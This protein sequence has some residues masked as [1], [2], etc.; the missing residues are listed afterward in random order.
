ML[1]IGIIFGGCAPPAPVT[2]P[3]TPVALNSTPGP[4]FAWI[5][6]ETTW[7]RDVN[8]TIGFNAGIGGE[9]TLSSLSPDGSRLAI[10]TVNGRTSSLRMI[11]VKTGKSE[12]LHDGV[13]EL[14]YSGSWSPD[15]TS[16]A[17][18]Y[19]VP[20]NTG[21]RPAMGAGSLE[22]VRV[23]DGEIS[24][25][26]CSVS[27]AIVAWPTSTE[28]LVRNADNLY[29]VSTAG[30]KTLSKTDVRKWHHVTV[31]PDGRVVA[32]ILRELAFVKENR[33]YEP[34]STLYVTTFGSNEAKKVAGDRYSPRNMTW[35]DDGSEL[36][37]DVGT[38]SGDRA[39][40]VF[41][42]A[43]GQSVFMN[44]TRS[45]SEYDPV[46]GPDGSLA[47]T[48]EDGRVMLRQA[49]ASFA[50]AIDASAYDDP[51]N[52]LTGWLDSST[53]AVVGNSG[54]TYS[55]DLVTRTAVRIGT[56]TL[57]PLLK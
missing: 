20:D 9:V 11:D 29:R 10:G 15:G 25:I 43:S 40:S 54:S 17:F 50:T 27:K 19:F 47:Y 13:A 32:Y 45:S 33:T 52:R 16:F 5:D 51:L 56:G 2:A 42:L 8:S 53:V 35:S 44:A 57:V 26:G 3:D 49:G 34:D 28:L 24:R 6:S 30:C 48:T 23:S 14:V 31:S 55:Y 4:S 18:G 12:L 41:D 1:V 37:F 36:A 46:W 21:D 39:I 38:P 22:R 7:I